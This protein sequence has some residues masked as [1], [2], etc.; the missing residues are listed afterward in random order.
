VVMGRGGE[1]R[2][3]PHEFWA[4]E[5]R[6]LQ[7]NRRLGDDKLRRA[8]KEGAATCGYLR[9]MAAME[10]ACPWSAQGELLLPLPTRPRPPATVVRSVAM[11]VDDGRDCGHD[12]GWAW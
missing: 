2:R 9:L 1:L 6:K 10:A 5:E 12:E 11:A 3:G 7:E 8:R 4:E